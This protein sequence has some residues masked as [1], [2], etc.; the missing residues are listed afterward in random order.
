MSRAGA[1]APRPVVAVTLGDPS[2]IGPEVAALALADRALWRGAVPLVFGDARLLER[3]AR[4]RRARLPRLAP[5]TKGRPAQA[6]LAAVGIELLSR[7]GAPDA[8]GAKFQLRALEAACDAIARREADA[9]CTGPV[10]KSQ[11]ASTGIAFIGQTE[12]LGERFGARVLMLMAGPRLRAAVATTHMPLAEVGRRLT[13]EGLV[14]DLR[15]LDRG[16]RE[17]FGIRRPRIAVAGLN[18]HAGEGGRFGSEDGEIV[19]PAVRAAAAAGIRVEGPLS[20]DG[21]FP[22]AARG[23]YDAVLAMYHDQGLIPVKL[24]DFERAVNVTL[25]LPFVRTSPDH[26]VAYEIA[27]KGVADA[28]SFKAAVRAA[29]AMIRRSAR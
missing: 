20:A 13:R 1:R 2:G 4:R 25:G 29:I 11:I 21:L 22:R 23:A 24:A 6:S 8:A 10:S 9:L 18:P 26:G 7:P 16:L 28:S 17:R 19:T 3:A 15:I 14:E 5:W 12:F 27:G